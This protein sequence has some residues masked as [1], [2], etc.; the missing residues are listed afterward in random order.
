[1]FP[2]EKW[3]RM[4]L[5]PVGSLGRSSNILSCFSSFPVPPSFVC[6]HLVC[7]FLERVLATSREKGRQ[8]AQQYTKFVQSLMAYW[9]LRFAAKVVSV[10]VR[11]LA[12]V[13]RMPQRLYF[14][15]YRILAVFSFSL[16]FN[17][18]CLSVSSILCNFAL[19]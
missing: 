10:R 2:W 7:L 19:A 13:L 8:L 16:L 3:K 11:C 15:S 6:R 5:I 9:G 18:N 12:I 4:F 17:A 14:L 1:M